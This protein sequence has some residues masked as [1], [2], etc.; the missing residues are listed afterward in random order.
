MKNRLQQSGVE[1]IKET[2]K[3]AVVLEQA[4]YGRGLD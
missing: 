3:E 1:E 4:R 2:H